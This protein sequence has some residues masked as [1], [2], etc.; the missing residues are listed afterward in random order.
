MTTG[1]SCLTLRVLAMGGHV[2][3]PAT[4]HGVQDAEVTDARGQTSDFGQ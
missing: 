2:A 3:Q 4:S 1:G